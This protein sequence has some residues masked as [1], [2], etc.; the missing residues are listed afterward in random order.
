M[1]QHKDT[2]TTKAE[3]RSGRS[4][5]NLF[6]FLCAL[7]VFVLNARAQEKA[8]Q[9]SFAKVYE[10]FAKNCASCHNPKD[11][12]GELSL[13]THETLLK[14]GETGPAIVAGKPGESLLLQLIEHK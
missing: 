8:D 12:K 9:P 7:C 4:V 3:L 11:L 13:E 1:F 14:G 2:K 6:L 5:R 10:I